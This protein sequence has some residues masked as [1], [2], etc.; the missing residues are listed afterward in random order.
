MGHILLHYVLKES[1][2]DFIQQH[3]CISFQ[4][5]ITVVIRII[6]M[7]HAFGMCHC[8]CLGNKQ[9]KSYFCKIGRRLIKG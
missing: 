8:L 3:V 9:T 7:W 6:P 5:H 4:H 1:P 2:L